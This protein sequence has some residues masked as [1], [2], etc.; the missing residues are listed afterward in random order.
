MS[1]RQVHGV[2]GD[3]HRLSWLSLFRAES[4]ANAA[5]FFSNVHTVG[6]TIA[7]GLAAAAGGTAFAG[8][9]TVAG[10]AGIAAAAVA[11]LLTVAKPDERTQSHWLTATK[12]SQVAEDVNGR[13][14][15]N[16]TTPAVAS[17]GTVEAPGTGLGDDPPR[18]DREAL[19]F[20][21][22]QI[23]GLEAASSP[24]PGVLIGRTEKRMRKN[25]QWFA[26]IEL[27]AFESWRLAKLGV[28][29]S[30]TDSG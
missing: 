11:G 9:T 21:R 5:R 29:S 10:V 7:A 19:E 6:G 4:H 25:K 8:E 12:Y 3:A 15:F 24:V 26:P 1:E 16:W 13:F 28:E 17:D 22:N 27:D 14:E 30:P 20:F 18:D 23:V 2:K